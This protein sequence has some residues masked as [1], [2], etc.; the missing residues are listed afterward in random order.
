MPDGF[1]VWHD[2]HPAREIMLPARASVGKAVGNTA[3]IST[4]S[5][6]WKSTGEASGTPCNPSATGV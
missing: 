2:E 5:W 4:A 3:R 1:A 6:G